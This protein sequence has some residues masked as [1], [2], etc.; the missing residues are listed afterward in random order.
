VASCV[1][2]TAASTPAAAQ[3]T[4]PGSGDAAFTL[5]QRRGFY[6]KTRRDHAPYV[7]A[8]VGLPGLGNM[9][10]D[11]PLLGAGFAGVF[12]V[13]A[14]LLGFGLSNDDPEIA[15]IGGAIIATTYAGSMVTTSLGVDAYNA[16]LRKRYKLDD[17]QAARGPLPGLTVSLRF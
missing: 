17:D 2:L 9:L 13:S 4:T 11:Q 1:A 5:E 14:V 7:L 15:I 8:N 10:N 12:A 3:A 6:E 16:Q